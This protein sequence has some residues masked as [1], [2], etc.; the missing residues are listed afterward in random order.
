MA[1]D[2][3]MRRRPLSLVLPAL[4]LSLL[5]RPAVSQ[6]ATS[7][8][9]EGVR[10]SVVVDPTFD[11]LGKKIQA[12]YSDVESAVVVR[13]GRVLFEHHDSGPDTLRDVQSVTKSVLS[14]AVGAAFGRGAIRSL[15]QPVSELL[16]IK[17][18]PD[19]ASSTSVTMRHLLTMTAGFVPQE[20]FAPGTADAL[21]FLLQRQRA[22][23]PGSVFAYDNLSTNL[24]SLVLEA[25]T[26]ELVSSFTEQAVFRPLGITS[27]E[28]A[29]GANG[30]SL[31]FS[32]LKLRTRDMARLGELSLRAGDWSGVQIVPEL[33]A[34][35]AVS[36]QNSGGVPVGLPYGYLWWVVPTA[37]GQSTYF[38][39][40]WGG[41]FIWVHPPL[42]LVIATT[43]AVSA[44]S[45]QRGQALRLI[46]SELFR[47]A[48]AATPSSS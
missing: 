5:H 41:Q 16:G 20:R 13:K 26:G 2:S 27:Y 25:A 36:A 45:N 34:R 30:H 48:S 7:A 6:P 35:A 28:W 22:A 40:G 4:A 47:A 43:S 19:S 31:G 15:D 37:T 39:S 1:Q 18:M 42:D 8:A 33:Y 14:L 46:R 29:Q 3:T 17:Q 44:N 24:L 11:Q 21:T 12:E 32:G 23:P 9:P 10:P 38:A